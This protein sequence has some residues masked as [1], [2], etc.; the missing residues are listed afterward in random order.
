MAAPPV[1]RRAQ[2]FVRGQTPNGG[3][4]G[5][6]PAHG[7][8]TEGARIAR[9]ARFGR[10]RVRTMRVRCG[11]YCLTKVRQI[12]SRRPEI[13]LVSCGLRSSPATSDVHLSPPRLR[14]FAASD[15]GC[16]QPRLHP[17]MPSAGDA[18]REAP[19][20][21][22]LRL[23]ER[24]L[25]ALRRAGA[26]VPSPRGGRG[27]VQLLRRGHLSQALKRFIFYPHLWPMIPSTTG[28]WPMADPPGAARSCCA[29]R[30]RSRSGNR[31]S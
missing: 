19:L 3:F 18:R 27:C 6:D 24:P 5:S 25:G 11:I 16:T 29:S 14:L 31:R 28:T 8:V 15:G 26:S 13:G 4:L 30:R 22:V 7:T 17:R 9:S 20:T 21:C 12:V 2:R 10:V 23:V 1:S